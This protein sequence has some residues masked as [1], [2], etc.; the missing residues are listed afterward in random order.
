MNIHCWQRPSK[1]SLCC[2][3]V[4]SK[5]LLVQSN[6]S[7]CS[8]ILSLICIQQTAVT[9]S[10]VCQ[11]VVSKHSHSECQYC[12]K[13]SSLMCNASLINW[14][15]IWYTVLLFL[16]YL[17]VFSSNSTQQVDILQLIL[18]SHIMKSAQTG[19]VY[20]NVYNCI[21]M[22]LQLQWHNKG[23]YM[24]LGLVEKLLTSKCS[25]WL[26][27]CDKNTRIQIIL[28]IFFSACGGCWY[29]RKHI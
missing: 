25:Y 20:S 21:F 18:K 27:H 8:L 23:E 13:R 28:H 3:C 15:Y 9:W 11:H 2:W 22:V 6:V 7:F 17:S 24:I 12:T 26:S 5:L 4:M 10:S 29:S 19:R 16:K 1:R 14:Y